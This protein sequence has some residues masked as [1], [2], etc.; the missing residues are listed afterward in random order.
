MPW[1]IIP[2]LTD[3]APVDVETTGYNV[4]TYI[5]SK[6]IDALVDKVFNLLNDCKILLFLKNRNIE[7]ELYQNSKCL[8]TLRKTS[9]QPVQICLGEE[10]SQVSL[11]VDDAPAQKWL[12]Y[13]NDS[14]K[15]TEE[16]ISKIQCD[17]R[18][19]QKLLDS[20]SFDLSFAIQLDEDGHV[21]PV[22]ESVLYT[23]LPT[24]YQFG[25]PLLVNANFITDAGRQQLNDDAEWNK[26]VVEHIPYLLLTWVGKLALG[27]LEYYCVLPPVSVVKKTLGNVYNNAM[28]HAVAEVAFIPNENC[29]KLVL[30]SEAILDEINLHEAFIEKCFNQILKQ[31]FQINNASQRLVDNA[32]LE[33]LKQYSV[34]TL[35]MSE[36]FDIVENAQNLFSDFTSKDIVRLIKWTSEN[37]ESFGTQEKDILSNSPILLDKD[38][39]LASPNELFFT[40]EYNYYGEETKGAKFLS[41][42]V[43]NGLDGDKV[44]L[45]E[46]GVSEV[47][48]LSI[49]EN[50]FCKEGYITI[51]S[52]VQIMRFI[53]KADKQEKVLDAIK[54]RG[55]GRFLSN[56]RILS[57]DGNLCNPE[58]LYLTSE[59]NAGIKVDFGYSKNLFVSSDYIE[60]GDDRYEWALFFKKL[61]VK[62]EIEISEVCFERGSYAYSRLQFC[63]D[64]TKDEYRTWEFDT[65]K[66][67]VKYVS[68]IY[69]QF[70]PIFSLDYSGDYRLYKAA[71]EQL[72]TKE[73]YLSSKEDFLCANTGWSW[74]MNCE[75]T[76]SKYLGEN[77]LPWALKEYPLMPSTTGRLMRVQELLENTSENK[78]LCG[79][80]FP[81]LNIEGVIDDSWH[82]Y[83][84]FKSEL[85]LSDLL[86]VLGEISG[87][88]ESIDDNLD[89]I[90]KIYDKIISFDIKDGDRNWNTISAWGETHKVLSKK[91]KFVS[92]SE[93]VLISYKLSG[94]EADNQ[95]FYGKHVRFQESRFVNFMRA[96]GVKFIDHFEP[97][98]EKLENDE[99]FK[100]LLRENA[101]FITLLALGADAELEPAMFKSENDK[102]LQN[103]DALTFERDESIVLCY[104]DQ[105]IP[106]RVFVDRDGVF[107]FEGKINMATIDLFIADL[108][109]QLSISAVGK[110]ALM[111]V[112]QVNGI[113]DKIDYLQEKGYDA[114]SIPAELIPKENGGQIGAEDFGMTGLSHQQQYAALV[115]A[116][117]TILHSMSMAG[118]D[119][120]NAK[121]NEWTN[122]DGVTKDGVEYPLVIHSNKWGSPTKINASD[123]LQLMRPNG[124]LA[125]NTSKG[126]GTLPLRQM[127]ESKEKITIR[128]NSSNLDSTQR[129]NEVA[130]VL[131]YFKG[132][133][134]DFEKFIP[135]AVNRWQRFMAPENATGEV[136]QASNIKLPK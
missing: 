59:Y 116:K 113:Q 20:T 56:L 60:P 39:N 89:R 104:G 72:L 135:V 33:G 128:F 57:T 102:M 66:F 31:Q 38:G 35:E 112:L 37:K 8:R 21:L 127:L 58:N 121:W 65:R 9:E 7:V 82:Q 30:A 100:E 134:I 114:M 115:E 95:V 124:M 106:K 136:A 47:S 81:V 28:A 91:H 73:I 133:Q 94:V 111:T 29:S 49:I 4:C 46:L 23:Y 123:W 97:K 2:I 48:R 52:A 110:S 67:Y 36:F 50:L 32:A 63:V 13:K 101:V 10:Q 17:S 5:R 15:L 25:F 54:S 80:Y 99:D 122:I 11:C 69:V 86:C 76:K 19:P 16:Q 1:Q 108:A 45:Q 93:L 90:S 126:P 103:I 74:Y 77:F 68:S 14:V 105:E 87:D 107:H 92:P 55:H 84:P 24:S 41:S 64:K 85:S 109:K 132:L 3:S 75:L 118:Y 27:G 26:A 12:I 22:K 131:R 71:W 125:I 18:T 83:L 78:E 130:T 42:D 79:K 62:D 44:W 70:C 119:I 61:G 120:S 34:R 43:L 6:N 40:P 51:G 96:L 88:E 117:D 129:I 53:F 98:Y